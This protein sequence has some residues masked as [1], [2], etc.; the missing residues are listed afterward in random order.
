MKEQQVKETCRRVVNMR[1]E[2]AKQ[3]ITQSGFMFRVT[4][5]DGMSY[6][7]TDNFVGYRIN[8]NIIDGIVRDANI[9]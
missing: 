1:T 5:E 2:A 3:L 7:S 6:Y 8:L 9:G 4:S